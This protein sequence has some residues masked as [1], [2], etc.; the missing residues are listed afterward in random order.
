MVGVSEDPG[1]GGGGY[2]VPR[3]LS[4]KDDRKGSKIQTQKNP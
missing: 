2:G 3:I 1:G 4:D